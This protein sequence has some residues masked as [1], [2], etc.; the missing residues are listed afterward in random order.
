MDS[1]DENN[2]FHL[3][4]GSNRKSP[5]AFSGLWDDLKLEIAL[6]FVG[7]YRNNPPY[8]LVFPGSKRRQAHYKE[9]WIL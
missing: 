4:W 5:T 6:S 9:G 7:I 1:A 8:Y 3:G 2:C